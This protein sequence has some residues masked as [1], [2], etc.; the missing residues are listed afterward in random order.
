[1]KSTRKPIKKQNS[2]AT[3]WIVGIIA[4]MMALALIVVIS[5]P[6]AAQQHALVAGTSLGQADAPITVEEYGDFQCPVCGQFARALPSIE[7]K[8]VETGKIR[9]VF[10]HMIV[11]SGEES[12]KAAEAAECAGEQDKFWEYY[13]TLFANQA[14]ELRG[15]ARGVF[16]DANLI[17]F[18]DQL[19]LDT[20]AFTTC[21]NSDKY[22]DKIMRDTNEAS[23]RG[24]QGTPTLFI[25][26]RKVNVTV[27]S[28]QQF[29]TVIGP[30]IN[31]L[32]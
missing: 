4:A 10:H 29:D 20:A 24:A 16:A 5:L 13:D 8:Y 21:L 11:I 31:S 22:R 3:W 15:A 2:A 12:I 1:M 6:G 26:D 14:G 19:K 18:A 32:K 27:V 28:P 23:A 7:K 17:K 30:Y 25:N 9:F